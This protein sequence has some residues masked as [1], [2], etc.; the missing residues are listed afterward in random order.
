MAR[1]RSTGNLGPLARQVRRATL[2][3]L[4]ALST[5]ACS[6]DPTGLTAIVGVYTLIDVDDDPLPART[7]S[8]VTHVTRVRAGTLSIDPDG[9]YA[10]T[11]EWELVPVGLSPV[12]G[13][14]SEVGTVTI[15]GESQVRFEGDFAT[16]TGIFEGDAM[17]V[18]VLLPEVSDT[19]VELRFRR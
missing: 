18:A 13:S 1:S 4:L 14:H 6:D 9:S 19:A 12:P 8:A 2:A 16:W 3:A 10:M 17:R 11:V 5:A 7:D 15:I